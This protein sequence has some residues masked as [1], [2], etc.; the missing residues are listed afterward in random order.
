M[1]QHKELTE[2]YTSRIDKLHSGTIE[3]GAV[4]IFINQL[5]AAGF[6]NSKLVSLN[7]ALITHCKKKNYKCID[8]A[9]NLDGKLDFWWD[10]IHTTP[11][12]SQE[13]ANII[14]PE[15]IKIF[16]ETNK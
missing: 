3:M 8:V 4:P 1:S 7:S 12:G 6:R 10:G 15:L 16:D 9:S 14:A 5:T 2:V 13:I 11:K